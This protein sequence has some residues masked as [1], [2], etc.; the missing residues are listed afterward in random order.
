MKE[1][2]ECGHLKECHKSHVLDNHGGEC[3]HCN[4]KI[5]TWISFLWTDKELKEKKKND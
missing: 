4:C 2:C 1:M 5:Y 3:Q